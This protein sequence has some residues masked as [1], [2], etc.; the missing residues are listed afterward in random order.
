VP[1]GVLDLV[2]SDGIRARKTGKKENKKN[3]NFERICAERLQP[4]FYKAL[5]Y[6]AQTVSER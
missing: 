5:R 6:F 4:L 2:E 1:A 3:K